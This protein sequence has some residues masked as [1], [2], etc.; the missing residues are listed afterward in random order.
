M[1]FMTTIVSTWLKMRSVCI[2][3]LSKLRYPA[4]SAPKGQFAA[5]VF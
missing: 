2:G 5:L 1:L 3:A 4:A